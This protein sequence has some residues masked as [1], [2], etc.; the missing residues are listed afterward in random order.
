MKTT[1]EVDEQLLNKAKQIL[2]AGT[3]RE[4]VE[5]SLQAVVRQALNDLADSFGSFEF[6]VTLE[7]QRKQRRAR[8][9]K[10]MHLLSDRHN[11]PF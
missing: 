11:Y 7:D 5:R 2:G 3:I 8:T 1:F 4:T 6:D 9:R 10:R